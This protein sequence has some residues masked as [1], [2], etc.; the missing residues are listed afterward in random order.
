MLPL[1]TLVAL[2][3]VS[4]AWSW[5]YAP[6][7]QKSTPPENDSDGIAPA[8]VAAILQGS[9]SLEA[10]ARKPDCFRRVANMIQTRCSELE[11]DE[12]ERVKA[13]LSM[14][15]CEIATADHHSLPLECASFHPDAAAG[16]YG[17]ETPGKC[18]SAISRSAQYWS[19]YSGYL[20][21]VSQLCFAF[22]R[23]NDI[24]TAK[25]VHRNAT[26]ASISVLRYLSNRETRMQQAWDE[27]DAM[28]QSLRAAIEQLHVSTADIDLVSRVT[29][30]KLS[31]AL[32][33]VMDATGRVIL[34]AYAA[35]ANT[36]ADTLSKIDANMS[37]LLDQLMFATASVAP[38]IENI[39][40]QRL[41]TAY[42][43]LAQQLQGMDTLAEQAGI[44]FAVLEKRFEELEHVA[45][46][47]VTDVRRAGADMEVYLRHSHMAQEKQLEVAAV[48]NNVSLALTD[49]VVMA[50]QG[51]HDLNETV[52]EVKDSLRDVYH[53]EWTVTLWSWFQ[54]L[55]MHVFKIHPSSFDVPL[56]HTLG[57]CIRTLRVVVAFVSSMLMVGTFQPLR[58][59]LLI[60]SFPRVRSYCWLPSANCHPRVG[61]TPVSPPRLLTLFSL[62][63]L[64]LDWQH[65]GQER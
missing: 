30:E 20:R 16:H 32:N 1:T 48:V 8:E 37:Q 53:R 65:L 41:D 64:E 52:A 24:D 6:S 49:L 62:S 5:V 38:T 17:T 43:S 21:E 50:H 27:S 3:P 4:Q 14:T 19:S 42:A 36:H 11:T 55:V 60:S 59:S 63:S 61:K 12:A 47:L 56:V 25:E 10:Y 22:Q 23:W 40:A 33:Q 54:E 44:R 18:V 35:A 7:R 58:A 31:L 9:R 26:V 45:A 57:E 39:L 15:L 13:A 29:A 28:L 46:F 2:L 51:V 34:D